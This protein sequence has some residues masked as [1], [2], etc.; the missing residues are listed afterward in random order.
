MN[1]VWSRVQAF[2][3]AGG[4]PDRVVPPTG[5]TVRMTVL[6]AA[7][8]A[9]LAVFALAL[10]LAAGRQA[11][12]WS[13]ASEGLTVRLTEA[14]QVE[15]VL[16]ILSTTPGVASARA[17]TAAETEALLE[18]WLGPDLPIESLPLPQLIA[19]TAGDGLDT[20]AL[21]IRLVAEAPGA[22]LDDH[23]RWRAPTVSA[24][25]RLRW[26]AALC[27]VMTAGAMAAIITLAANAALAANAQPIRVLRL[28]GARDDYIAQAFIRRFAR[29]AAIGAVAGT[30]L[31]AVALALLPGGDAGTVLPTLAF[32]GAGW[33]WL[34]IVPLA[35]VGIALAAAR[36]A[37]LRV[38][39]GLQ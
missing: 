10:S 2:L 13:G 19:V 3:G 26:L 24:A 25:S 37:T 23:D 9:F 38:L 6:S 28:V 4:A 14:A 17:L 16:S 29:R 33:L 22:V 39:R 27:A 31:G 15:P 30:L 35:A 8:M 12:L 32:S 36:A 1:G 20:E 7:C 18:P 21:R 34:L 11:A 5:A